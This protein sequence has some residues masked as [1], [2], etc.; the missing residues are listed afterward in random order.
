ML[1][2]PCE[3][4]FGHQGV[5]RASVQRHESSP[6]HRVATQA[7]AITTATN[8]DGEPTEDQATPLHPEDVTP[9]S[10]STTD[11][12]AVLHPEADA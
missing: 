5:S 6:G 8:K 11:V 9:C 2:V 10:C 1:V 12:S 4:G 3:T 7:L